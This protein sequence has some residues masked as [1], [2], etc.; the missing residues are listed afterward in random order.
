[1]KNQVQLLINLKRWGVY[2]ILSFLLDK[3]TF[4]MVFLFLYFKTTDP[5]KDFGG[6][7]YISLFPSWKDGMSD[8]LK[9]KEVIV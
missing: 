3:Q 1:M 7:S 9:K 8:V 2:E 4:P 5:R 6:L